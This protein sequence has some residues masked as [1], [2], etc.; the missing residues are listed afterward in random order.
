MTEEAELP[1]KA[2]SRRLKKWFRPQDFAWVFF[3]IVLIAATPEPNYDALILL[4]L[5][6]T[7]QIL[8]PRLKLFSS[9]RGQIVSILLKLLLSYLLIG[10]SHGLE[11]Y[12]ASIFLIPI[13]SAAT[14]FQLTGVI[15]VT[16]IACLGYFSFLFPFLFESNRFQLTPEVVSMACLRSAFYAIVAFVVYEEAQAKREE[17]QRTQEAMAQLEASNRNLRRAETSLR[18]SERLAA[19]GQLTAGLAHELRNPLGTIKASSEMLMKDTAK[20]DS[21]LI[22]EMAGF[23]HCEADRMNSL[24]GSFL[25]FAR[26]LQIH[27][28]MADLRPVVADVLREQSERAKTCSVQLRFEARDEADLRFAFDPDTLR[29]ALS[30]LVQN[31]IQAS[32]P[33]QAVEVSAQNSG[34][35]IELRVTDHGSGIDAEHLESIFNPFFTTKPQGVGLGLALVSKIVD[36]HGGK[37]SVRSEK[38]TGTVFEISLPKEQP[39][40]S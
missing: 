3:I 7:F 11:S 28:T 22:S 26:P 14:T 32:E 9:R 10:Y 17:V 16:A 12:Y 2:A 31:A 21:E 27:A 36:E 35:R 15:A 25:T 4:P 18:R 39:L 13:V 29:V 5:I 40:E 30:N 8:E 20:D 6:G 33:G 38:G 37:I 19:L 1:G 23:I 34:E 24:I